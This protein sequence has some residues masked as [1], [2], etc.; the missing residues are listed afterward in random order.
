VS[1]VAAVADSP[2]I[3][4][5]NVVGSNIANIGL[6][7]GLV[8]LMH[9]MRVNWPH[10][11][12]DA[13]LMSLVTLLASAA[14]WTGVTGVQTGLLL[15]AILLISVYL[16][17]RH[18]VAVEEIPGGVDRGD[19]RSRIV[20]VG[21]S[22]V[23]LAVLVASARLMVLSAEEIARAFG[24]AESIIGATMVAVGTSIP[25]L[26]ASVVAVARGH[27]DIGIGNLVGSNL[28]N[29][30]FVFGTVCLVRPSERLDSAESGLLLLAMLAFTAVLLPMLATGGRVRR[31]EGAMLL[32]GYV[33]FS[34]F[35]YFR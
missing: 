31:L 17:L 28:M 9:P 30:S 16:A 5:G 32:G 7:L 33:A 15:W 12:R 2:G 27:Y 29:L 11:R 23:G 26:A 4:I 24:I 21:Q 35:A 18:P 13:L 22:V 10:V 25:E 6:I 34:W 3:A 14:I 1:I 20:A 8:S 19:L